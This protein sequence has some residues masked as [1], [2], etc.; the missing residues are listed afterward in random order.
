MLRK[1]FT[2]RIHSWQLCRFY[3]LFKMFNPSKI[4]YT[5]H[6]LGYCRFI[7]HLRIIP[8]SALEA[9][10][11]ILLLAF[12][13]FPWRRPI[14]STDAKRSIVPHVTRFQTIIFCEWFCLSQLQRPISAE[15]NEFPRHHWH[16]HEITSRITNF[17]IC[18]YC[19]VPRVV[20][21]KQQL[22]VYKLQRLSLE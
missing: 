6:G 12:S 20:S 22:K 13:V 10:C 11:F 7:N 5:S 2:E 21:Y 15:N 17:P 14:I 16:C 4:P 8:G 19:C 3:S 1:I 18:V 9:R